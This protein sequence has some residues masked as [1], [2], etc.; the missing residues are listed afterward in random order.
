MTPE[1]QDRVVVLLVRA[2]NPANIGAAA[3]AMH[4]LGF[5]HLRVVNEFPVPFAAAKSAVDAAS[6]LADAGEFAGVAEAVADCTWVLGTTA[7][8]ERVLEHPLHLLP[9]AAELVRERVGA[10]GERI[11]LLFGSEKTGL[12]NDELSHCH[13]LVTIP[14]NTRAGEGEQARHLSMNLGQAVAVC[15]YALNHAE[16]P[17]SSVARPAEGQA[18]AGEVE[19]LTTLLR[20]VLAESGYSRRNPANAR[21]AVLR[22]L[23]RRM[24]LAPADAAVWTGVLRQMQHALRAAH[25]GAPDVETVAEASDP[26]GRT[27]CL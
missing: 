11:A 21:E 14:M 6:V 1:Q 19:R 7:V 24:A 10:A 9:R 5:R 15:L 25:H 22:R 4:D 26:E 23:V 13:A 20:E 8:G 17:L 27:D 18:S 3:R 12:S 2:R 16:P